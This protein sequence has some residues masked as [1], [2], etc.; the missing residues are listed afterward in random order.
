MWKDFREFILRGNVIDLAVG[1]IIGAAFTGVINSLVNDILLPPIG[2]LLGGVDFSNLYINLSGGE[3]A[4][5]AAAQEAGAATLNYGLFLNAI[6]NFLIVATA[7]FALVRFV[8]QVM[9][10]GKKPEAATSAPAEPSAEQKL[11]TTLEKLNSTLEKLQ[12]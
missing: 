4:S 3:F 5:L 6:L 9:V 12:K 10:R 8:N 1:I 7:M 2:L 11:L